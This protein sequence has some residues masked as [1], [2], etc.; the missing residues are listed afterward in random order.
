MTKCFQTCFENRFIVLKLANLKQNLYNMC[1]VDGCMVSKHALDSNIMSFNH[2][3]V[4]LDIFLQ[5]ISLKRWKIMKKRE[6]YGSLEISWGKSRYFRLYLTAVHWKKL[7]ICGEK[8]VKRSAY[9]PSTPLIWVW[10]MLKSSIYYVEGC[11]KI[12]PK[13]SGLDHN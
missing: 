3:K 6:V 13:D 11:L 4:H 10:V 5:N 7:N 8:M 9:L 2:V 12:T 1:F